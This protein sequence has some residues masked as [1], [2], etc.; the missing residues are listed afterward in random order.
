VDSGWTTVTPPIFPWCNTLNRIMRSV[1]V[2]PLH[3]PMVFIASDSAGAHRS[4]R[5]EAVC[6]LYVDAEASR[7]WESQRRNVRRQFI[8]DGRRMA[9]ERLG[10]RQRR[11]AVMPF[12]RAAEALSGV[13]VS[14]VIAKSLGPVHGDKILFDRLRVSI[15]FQG[16]WS[17]HQ[18]ERMLRVTHLVAFLA[19]GLSRPGQQIYW[20]SD[21]DNI[22]ADERKSA[23]SAK[24]V[25]GFTSRYVRHPLGSLGV[26]TT[27]LDEG[28]RFEEDLAA[29]PDLVA[30]TTAE[31]ATQLAGVCGGHI[32]HKIAIPFDRALPSKVDLLSRWVYD[33][34]GSFKR[35]VVLFDKQSDGAM[36]VFRLDMHEWGQV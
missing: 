35:I 28:D 15:P 26:G 7:D 10:D 17:D 24:M 22:F 9:F 5:Y 36:S 3:G 29:I 4:S 27:S 14:L 30:G 8:A 32:P 6:V 13:C 25:S 20:V 1:A 34:T 2:P 11:K 31:L 23:D 33:D 21:Q 12:L 16:R 19:G 18:L